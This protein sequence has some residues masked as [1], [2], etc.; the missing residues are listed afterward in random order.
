[1][2]AE[3]H[4]APK[5]SFAPFLLPAEPF[6]SGARGGG[7]RKKTRPKGQTKREKS[8]LIHPSHVTVTATLP[9]EADARELEAS[10]RRC[11]CPPPHI[12]HMSFDKPTTSDRPS[13]GWDATG[14]GDG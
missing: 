7:N 12:C 3:E 2:S 9:S 5:L 6:P 14:A 1:M 4:K 11:C 10:N 13:R 8:W